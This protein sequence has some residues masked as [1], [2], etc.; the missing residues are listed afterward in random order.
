MDGKNNFITFFQ[1]AEYVKKHLESRYKENNI[2]NA[3]ELAYKNGFSLVYYI[4]MGESF[5]MQGK[6]VPVSIK[7]VLYY[8][9]LSNWLKGVL[10]T[11]D[12]FYPSTTQ[13][14]AHG[15][16]ARKRKKQGYC[17]LNDEIKVQKDGFF[18][19]ISEKIFNIKQVTGEKY[20]MR[21]LLM[22]IPELN[23]LFTEL[24][25]EKPLV[26]AVL[27]S[28]GSVVV[29]LKLLER[30]NLT[31]SK[32]EKILSDHTGSDVH[33]IADKGEVKILNGKVDL[34][35]LPVY[36]SLDQLLY[37]PALL[38]LY[39]KLPEVLSHFLVLFNL[40][41]ICR[42]ETEWWGEVLYSFSSN[43][44]PFIEYFLDITA[45]KA[46]RLLETMFF[47]DKEHNR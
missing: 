11:H 2:P 43:D 25:T 42:Y 28:D 46:P 32:Y 33:C 27:D 18:P 19:C 6:E 10:L 20:K 4:K 3:T 29:P 45:Q 24:E 21:H 35:Q 34:H 1:S 16:S 23:P 14:L 30:L 12:P 7:P 41:M 36:K 39:N 17:F 31:I 44:K 22:R 13:V 37:I 47:P 40:S 8:Y 26:P 5:F 38:P 15:V 9:G